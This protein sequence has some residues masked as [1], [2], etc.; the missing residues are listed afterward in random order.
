MIALSALRL[1]ARL[2]N[3]VFLNSPLHIHKGAEDLADAKPQAGRMSHY[4]SADDGAVTLINMGFPVINVGGMNMAIKNASAYLS[5]HQISGGHGD[6]TA[7]Q[8]APLYAAEVQ[9]SGGSN[10]RT[11]PL[12][13]TQLT[14]LLDKDMELLFP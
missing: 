14:K 10:L 2:D 3:A 9:S 11:N 4:W 5:Q 7:A 1:G 12:F 8:Y 6:S 13:I